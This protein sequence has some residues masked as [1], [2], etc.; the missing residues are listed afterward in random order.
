MVEQVVVV[1]YHLQVM[2]S[3]LSTDLNK[4]GSVIDHKTGEELEV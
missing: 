1:N 3:L 4:D 2:E